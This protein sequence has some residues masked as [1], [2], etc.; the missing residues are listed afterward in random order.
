MSLLV[1]RRKWGTGMGKGELIRCLKVRSWEVGETNIPKRA[2]KKLH[3]INC[4]SHRTIWSI[5]HFIYLKSSI[6]REENYRSTPIT[7]ATFV[8]N[9]FQPITLINLLVNFTSSPVNQIFSVIYSSIPNA[10]WIN[11]A[12]SNRFRS[13]IPLSNYLFYRK[14]DFKI[15]FNQKCTFFSLLIYQILCFRNSRNF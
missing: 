11:Y 5:A 12:D 10:N 1:N 14:D 3:K 6:V 15:N 9:Y 13:I 7:S 2:R 4:L 8:P